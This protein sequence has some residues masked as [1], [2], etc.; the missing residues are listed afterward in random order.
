MKINIYGIIYRLTSPENRMYI[1]KTIQELSV[2]LQAHKSHQTAVNSELTSDIIRFGVENFMV[3]TLCECIS[4][5]ELSERE[6]FYINKHREEGYTLY[7]SNKDIGKF[8]VAGS[9]IRNGKSRQRLTRMPNHMDQWLQDRAQVRHSNV[10]R[11]IKE[12]IG[13]RYE[14]ETGLDAATGK[15]K[16][17]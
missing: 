7:N 4:S 9:S 1:G 13:A 6:V 11:E 10:S 12:I 5:Q 3:E 14:A 15:E 17:T 16:N 2:R 8:V